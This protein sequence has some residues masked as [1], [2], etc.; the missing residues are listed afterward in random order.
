MDNKI[1]PFSYKIR[2]LSIDQKASEAA[3][4]ASMG[5][6]TINSVYNARADFR[7]PPGE[8]PQQD[9]RKRV[10]VSIRETKPQNFPTAS[11][12]Q[13]G[14]G[15]KRK[16]MKKSAH[17]RQNRWVSGSHSA[18]GGLLYWTDMHDGEKDEDFKP[19]I[20]KAGPETK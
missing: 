9:Q 4:L 5:R 2:N 13:N 18:R 16:W 20:F 7:Q 17:Q 14:P 19:I 12:S 1:I 10:G 3:S 6:D 8:A 11:Q 15:K